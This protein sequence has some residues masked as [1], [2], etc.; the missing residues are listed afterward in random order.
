MAPLGCQKISPGAVMLR[1][2]YPFASGHGRSGL[3]RRSLRSLP[4]FSLGFAGLWVAV[5]GLIVAA[6][7]A[8]L[9]SG[10]I[11]VW[12]A[13]CSVGI[14]TGWAISWYVVR[15]TVMK[16]I[17]RIATSMETLA[18]RD[19]LMLVDEF[20]NLADGAEARDIRVHASPVELPS[21]EGTRRLAEALNATISRLQGTVHQFRAAS[22]E[23]C[24]RLFYVGPDDY[25]LG[26]GCAE[27]MMSMLPNGG[28]VLMLTPSFKHAGIEMRRRGFESALSERSSNIQL[29]GAIESRYDRT[30]TAELLNSFLPTHPRLAGIYCTEATG[31]AGCIDALAQRNM[32]DR[33]TV[34]CH[35]ALDETMTYLRAGQIAAVVTQDP[36]GQGHDTPIH[37]F[38]HLAFG[39]MPPTP[40]LITVSDTITRENYNQFWQP[41]GGLIETAA[42]AERRARPLGVSA[43]PLRIAMMGLADSPFWGPVRAGVDAAAQ[44]LAA[45][46]ASV[47]WVIPEGNSDWAASVRGPAIEALA[48]EG[49]DAIATPA[50][51]PALVPYLNR[52]TDLGVVVATVNSEASS[53]QGLVATLSKE[54][55]QLLLTAT[56]L[57]IVA[58]RDSLTGAFNRSLMDEDL[59]QAQVSGAHS[60]RSSAVL[61]IDIDHFKRYNDTY[62]HTEGDT[63]LRMVA[64]RIQ[65]EIR[66]ADRLYRYGGEEFL[67]LLRESSVEEGGAA[68]ARIARS[69]TSL[70]IAH[71]RNDPWGVVTVSVGVAELAPDDPTIEQSVEDA[72][73]ALYRSKSAGRNTVATS[74][75]GLLAFSENE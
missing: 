2:E 73:A 32:Q 29:V 57:E 5:T 67:V 36:F 61:M 21:D 22:Q 11:S 47:E 28:Q 10:L 37:L 26:T 23:P 17:E 30:R 41:Y 75:R 38:N 39:W 59:K 68:A 52:A 13:L 63:V 46:N 72:D 16:P 64:Q 56:D 70:G 15:V 40:R 42:M 44:E 34:I 62:G 51:D 1:S 8:G 66:P 74:R 60:R 50:Y 9:G 7:L 71:E 3:L 45:C 48:V 55:K 49:Y 14:G 31:A 24:K 35:D 12:L 65:R 33:V 18:A 54:R 19:V 4:V 6:V 20:A 58:R 27:A 25:L 43:R 53:L 69:I